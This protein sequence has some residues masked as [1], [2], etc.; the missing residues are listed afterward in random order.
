MST[1]YTRGLRVRT[2]CTTVDEL[3]DWFHPFCDETSIYI[4]TPAPRAEGTDTVF[5]IDLANDESALVGEGVV[6]ASFVTR[7]NRFGQPGMQI[8]VRR[9]TRTSVRV[10]EQIL[11][12]RAVAA[13]ARK[14]RTPSQLAEEWDEGTQ[15]DAPSFAEVAGVGNAQPVG[16]PAS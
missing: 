12:A 7:D 13:D 11:I 1:R 8:G 6:L 5:S 2:R 9:L 14:E 10:F 16:S 3:V 4:A 15:V